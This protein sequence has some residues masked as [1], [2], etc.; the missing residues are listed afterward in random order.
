MQLKY[1]ATRTIVLSFFNKKLKKYSPFKL[2]IAKIAQVNFTLLFS[3]QY[4]LCEYSVFAE[5]SACLKS[6]FSIFDVCHQAD[7]QLF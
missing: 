2:K 4:T 6:K 5:L 7:A 1:D 3:A